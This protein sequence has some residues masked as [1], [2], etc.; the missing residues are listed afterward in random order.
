MP[1]DCLTRKSIVL[2][3]ATPPLLVAEL[4]GLTC[5]VDDVGEHHGSKDPLQ[6]RASVVSVTCQEFLDVADQRLGIAS[7]E[8]VIA[9]GIFD[10]ARSRLIGAE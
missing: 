8:A 5:G 9:F 10:I 4:G 3:E 1:R 7:P 2:V 6:L